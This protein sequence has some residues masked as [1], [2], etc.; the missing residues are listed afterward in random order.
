MDQLTLI[1]ISAIL[2][3]VF[4]AI[5][6]YLGFTKGTDR[7]VDKILDK[8]EERSKKSPT[9]QRLIK[10]LETSDKLFGDDQ[11]IAQITRFFK[12]AGDLLQSPEAKNLFKNLSS[13]SVPVDAPPIKKINKLQEVKRKN[14]PKNNH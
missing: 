4:A 12:A 3:G 5:G 2:N 6:L 7:T 11:A 1:V 9:A 13:Y 8:I 10:A 14:V